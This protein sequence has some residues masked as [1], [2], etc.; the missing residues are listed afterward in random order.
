MG[1]MLGFTFMRLV[2]MG[3]I[4]IGEARA[5]AL[6]NALQRF[7][8]LV[9]NPFI[10]CG[11]VWS[12]DLSD[13]RTLAFP[14]VGLFALI[15]GLLS[16]FAG[17]RLLALPPERAGVYVTCSSFTNIGSIGGVVLYLLVGE[18]A[19]ALLP[20][21]KLFEDLWYYGMLFPL[22]RSYGDKANATVSESA[23]PAP[24]DGVIR[25]LKDPFFLVAGAGIALGIGLNFAGLERPRQYGTAISFFIPASSFVLLFTI[26]MRIRFRV[27]RSH[28]KAASMILVSKMMLV[29]AAALAFSLILGLG[30][31]E[32]G[33]GFKVVLV[34]ASMPV[35]FLGMVPPALYRLDLDF[36]NSIWLVSNAALIV[37]VPALSILIDAIA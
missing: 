32:G 2:K 14:L 6:R 33:M 4:N 26:G 21:Y 17:A 8:L 24:M 5:E 9:I 10:F 29:P 13:T 31:M 23:R 27:A 25:V 28:W 20:F 36:A 3:K 1:L 37:I 7:T 11:A 19:F 35:G 22:A 30:G 34:L 18:P 12:L 16:G 15:L